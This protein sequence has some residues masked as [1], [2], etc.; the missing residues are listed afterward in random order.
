MTKEGY[1]HKEIESIPFP[2]IFNYQ[3][4]T[5]VELSYRNF[6]VELLKT[7]KTKTRMKIIFDIK[8]LPDKLMCSLCYMVDL[9]DKP[10]MNRFAEDFCLIIESFSHD[11]NREVFKLLQNYFKI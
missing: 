7:Q 6:D 1:Q 2:I 3:N 9:F 4:I 5:D 8:E 11:S 10:I